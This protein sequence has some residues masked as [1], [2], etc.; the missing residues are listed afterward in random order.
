VWTRQDALR[1]IVA[2]ARRRIIGADAGILPLQGRPSVSARAL[3]ELLSDEI[4]R[5]RLR[6]LVF[7]VAL[8]DSAPELIPSSIGDVSDIDRVF[9][10][11]RAVTSPR[12]L[13]TDGR[14]PAPRAVGAILG[15]LD[16]GDVREALVLA[17]RRLRASGCALH[18]PLREV[19]S[20]RDVDAL[21]AALVTPLPAALEDRLIRHAVR[22][23]TEMFEPTESTEVC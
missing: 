20:G 14:H 8:I 4:D 2:L 7:G 6:D 9:C 12:F 23:S 22:P 10:A 18:A 16:A 5:E 3:R 1:N 11:L 21:A 19:G 13:Q 17:E 15:R